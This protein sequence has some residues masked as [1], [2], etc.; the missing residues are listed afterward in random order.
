MKKLLI[1]MLLA[2]SS[3]YG[4]EPTEEMIKLDIPAKEEKVDQKGLNKKYY[5]ATSSTL[6]LVDMFQTLDIAE[7]P[8][9]FYETNP[10]LGD[11]PSKEEVYTYFASALVLN[12]LAWKYLP[13]PWWKVQQGLVMAIQVGV[14]ANNVNLGIGFSF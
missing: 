11:H 1:I 12:Y 7:N 5:L 14:I 4:Y 10:V 2:A 9:K 6:L 13:E 3:V 8:D